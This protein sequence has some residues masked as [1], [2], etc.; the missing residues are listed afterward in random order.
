MT[1]ATGPRVFAGRLAGAPVYDPLGDRVGKVHD[2]VVVFRLRGNPS[3][4][5]L[6]VDVTGKRR[7]FLPLTRV[8]SIANGQV[9]TTGLLNIRRFEQRP[10]ETMVLGELLDR[11]V[12]FNDGSG[13]ASVVDV[14]IEQV[15]NR[16]WA[17]MTLYVRMGKDSADAGNTK[18]VS[19]LE[20]SGLRT[21][22]ANQ[23]ATALLAQINELK[24]PDV[25]DLLS[26]L[27][28][29]RAI[30]VASQMHDHLLAD[31]LEEMSDADRVTI[32][33]ALEVERAADILEEM[34]PDDAADL[35]NDLPASKAEILLARMEPEEAQDVRRLMSY[36]ERTAGGMMTTEPLI[37]S[38]DAH[39]AMLLAAARRE[40]IPPA[41]ASMC[42]I[43]RPP[44]ETP[45]GQYL[46]VVHLQRA[47]REPPSEMVGTMID[48]VEPLSPDDGIGTITR[49]LATYNLTV[50]PVVDNGL[51]VGAVSVDDVLD[52]LMP[53]D[54]RSADEDTVDS[55]MD[56]R[57]DE[58]EENSDA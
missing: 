39:V 44:T 37:L 58:E 7:V 57:H 45:T 55:H 14:A 6:V 51:L 5:G 24:A 21:K 29:E 41:I 13:T 46:G 43:V 26:D 42:F 1:V 48:Q 31:V 23:A 38:P 28:D 10:S 25:A 34:E 40:D 17:L 50:L 18:L 16:Q 27:P 20:V 32:M 3:A 4:V 35:V 53:R 36:G 11:E 52:H 54:W 19:S 56:E 2:I 30:A 9:I 22:V 15:G 47:L 8:T 12:T 33:S 49:L